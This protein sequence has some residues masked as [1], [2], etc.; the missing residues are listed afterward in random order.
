[1]FVTENNVLTVLATNFSFRIQR[2]RIY[3]FEK[4][5]EI[6]EMNEREMKMYCSP[7]TAKVSYKFPQT[8]MFDTIVLTEL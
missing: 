6:I 4:P 3:R 5:V 1:M 7:Q 8:K 2:I